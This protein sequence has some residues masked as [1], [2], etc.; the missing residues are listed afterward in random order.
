MFTGVG[1]TV[2]VHRAGHERHA[3]GLGEVAVLGQHGHGRQHRH[4]RLAHGHDVRAGPEHLQELDDVVDDLVQPERAVLEAD[5]AG[6]VPVRD[7]H[8]VVRQ[9]RADGVGEQG[10]EVPGQRGD[11][12][13]PRLGRR[14]LGQVLGEAQQRAERRPRDD[15]LVHGDRPHPGRGL[16]ADLV[17]PEGEPLVGDRAVDED[18]VRGAQPADGIQVGDRGRQQVQ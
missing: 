1:L 13:H 18:L 3:R 5:V 17:D 14:A 2:D 10:R 8:V 4:A 7:V 16:D 6:V 12:Q 9:Q 11:D 15:L